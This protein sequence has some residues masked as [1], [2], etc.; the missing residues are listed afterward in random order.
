MEVLR[1]LKKIGPE[2]EF[3][4]F[5][6][7]QPVIIFQITGNDGMIECLAGNKTLEQLPG[8]EALNK[9]CNRAV[10]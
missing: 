2:E 10:E 1:M 3:A 4:L 8:I 6:Q 7:I 5:F 9:Q